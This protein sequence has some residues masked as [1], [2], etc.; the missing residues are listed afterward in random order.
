MECLMRDIANRHREEMA[1]FG[2][3]PSAIEVAQHVWHSV[4]PDVRAKIMDAASDGKTINA[5]Y[6]NCL[7][8]I[9]E[10]I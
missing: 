8:V 3:Q 7:K 5:R 2:Y 6:K 10:S 9:A 4:S 1:D